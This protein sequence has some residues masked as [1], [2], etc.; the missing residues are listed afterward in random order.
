MT[1]KTWVL[2]IASVLI[3]V[4]LIASQVFAADKEKRKKIVLS[5]KKV[6]PR[7]CSGWW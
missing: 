6:P 7:Q 2:V 1:R 3:S 5:L 4:I